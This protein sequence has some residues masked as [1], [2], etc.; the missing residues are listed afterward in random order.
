MVSKMSS[1]SQEV[2]EQAASWAVLRDLNDLTAEQQ[3]E[4]KQWLHADR[5]HLGAYARAEGALIR[6]DRAYSG[7]WGASTLVP[8]E[9][10]PSWSRRR[11][12]VGGAAAASIA[13]VGFMGRAIWLRRSNPEEIFATGVGQVREIL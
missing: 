4:F 10:S 2:D 12:V 13:A 11:L 6:V 7:G 9:E 3:E 5:R 1:T 8:P